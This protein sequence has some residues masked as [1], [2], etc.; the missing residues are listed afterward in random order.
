MIRR[1]PRSTLF[2]YT[3]LFRSGELDERVSADTGGPHEM[4]RLTVAVRHTHVVDEIGGYR[5][6]RGVTEQP[7]GHR[8]LD[9][10]PNVDHVPP[11]NA[12]GDEDPGGAQVER[13]VS[14]TP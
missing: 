7:R 8:V 4:R 10:R 13:H 5:V 3:T 12:C 2:P 6:P 1:P 9:Q 11:A 14:R